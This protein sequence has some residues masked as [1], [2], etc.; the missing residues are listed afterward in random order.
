MVLVYSPISMS[1]NSNGSARY[2]IF[3]GLGYFSETHM[4]IM[5]TLRESCIQ[6]G[7]FAICFAKH[8]DECAHEHVAYVT[9]HEEACS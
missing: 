5:A 7:D 3:Q 1:M 4:C 8:N 2:N 6:T 9:E